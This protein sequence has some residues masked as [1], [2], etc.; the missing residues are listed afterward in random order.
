MA[1][2]AKSL[3]TFLDEL[4]SAEPAPGGG[5]VAA[6]SGALAA[7]LVAM[8][9]RLTIGKKGYDAVSAEMQTILPRAEALQ[10]E[11][12]DLM[13]ADTN[14][15]SRVMDAYKLPKTTDD[16]KAARARAIQAALQHASDVP[17]RVAELCI[18]VL[19]LARVVAEKGNKNAASDGGVGALMAEAGTRGAAFNVSINLGSIADETFVQ[20]RRARVAELLAEAQRAKNEILQIAEKRL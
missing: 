15:Y 11:L 7:S 16:E 10:R 14:A 20:D 17:L 12:A 9:C 2:A 5:S 8:V 19:A 6:L 4:A 3:Q 13:Q 18:Q 1:F